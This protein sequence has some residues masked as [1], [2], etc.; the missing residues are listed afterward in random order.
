MTAKDEK[1]E[2]TEPEATAETAPAAEAAPAVPT[3]AA[4]AAATTGEASSAAETALSALSH[5]DFMTYGARLLSAP[6]TDMSTPDIL[7]CMRAEFD[8]IRSDAAKAA[9][10]ASREA[11]QSADDALKD[12]NRRFDDYLL[13]RAHTP[14]AA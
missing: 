4:P 1:P 14:V 3:D 12:M 9:S 5:A 13:M 8:R 2:V 7:G 6:R 11:Q 10:D